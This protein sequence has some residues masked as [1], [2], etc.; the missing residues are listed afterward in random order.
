M[1]L[2]GKSE[3][4]FLAAYRESLNCSCRTLVPRP[5]WPKGPDFRIYKEENM[6][7]TLAMLLALTMV[8]ALC[9]CGSCSDRCSRR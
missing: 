9:A 4:R 1:F 5:M 8:F 6:K 3:V 2:K 7:K